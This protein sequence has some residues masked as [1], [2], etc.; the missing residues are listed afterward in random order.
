[1]GKAWMPMTGWGHGDGMVVDDDADVT[2]QSISEMF[3]REY[4]AVPHDVLPR[5]FALATAALAHYYAAQ[6]AVP[7]PG[8]HFFAQVTPELRTPWLDRVAPEARAAHFFRA[9]SLDGFAGEGAISINVVLEGADLVET[10]AHEV[11]HLAGYD[12][13]QAQ[14]YGRSAR[15]DRRGG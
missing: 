3:Q 8:V 7:M 10:V 1:M 9:G 12:E 5:P 6:L 13:L 11:A 2:T 15:N 4:V 14:A